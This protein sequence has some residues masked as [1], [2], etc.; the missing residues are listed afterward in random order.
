M[1]RAI[2]DRTEVERLAGEFE[3]RLDASLTQR[4][5]RKVNWPRGKPRENQPVRKSPEVRFQLSGTSPA[6]A[7]SP[8]R[9]RF[10]FCN[11]LM[12]GELGKIDSMNIAVQ[13]NFPRVN[14]YLANGGVCLVDDKQ[15]IWIG[16]TGKMT[17]ASL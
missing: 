5:E 7:W 2:T 9:E 13:V 16:H 11:L 1:Y 8:D 15:E 17:R 10:K 4:E 6:R 12:F 3:K 14:F